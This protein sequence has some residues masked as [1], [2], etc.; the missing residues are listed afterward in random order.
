M[1]KGPD[2][3][4]M[5]SFQM[6]SLYLRFRLPDSSWPDPTSWPVSPGVMIAGGEVL[7]SLRLTPESSNWGLC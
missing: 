3:K 4:V 7:G 6:A 2:S 5:I 1:I